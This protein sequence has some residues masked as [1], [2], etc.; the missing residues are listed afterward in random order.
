MLEYIIMDAQHDTESPKLCST[1]GCGRKHYA[2][3]VCWPEYRKLKGYKTSDRSASASKYNGSAIAQ[4]R[5]RQAYWKRK[6][7]KKITGINVVT[8][9]F[10]DPEAVRKLAENKAQL[11]KIWDLFTSEQK[12]LIEDAESL[13]T[14]NDY[15]QPND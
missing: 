5:R 14:Q 15:D 6:A 4:E 12:Q 7:V 10:G 8:K 3:G 13:K 2:L 9:A 1:P 11:K